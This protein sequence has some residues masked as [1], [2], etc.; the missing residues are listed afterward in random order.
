M[1]HPSNTV[2]LYCM[3]KLVPGS[4]EFTIM[5]ITLF[6]KLLVSSFIRLKGENIMFANPLLSVQ[7]FSTD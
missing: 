4:S 1:G 2:A 5:C 3:N 6:T 7:Y